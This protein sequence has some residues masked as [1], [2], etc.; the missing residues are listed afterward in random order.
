MGGFL[1]HTFARLSNRP[2]FNQVVTA[3]EV[4]QMRAPAEAHGK[5]RWCGTT[6]PCSEKNRPK[7]GVR[8]EIPSQAATTFEELCRPQLQKIFQTAYRITR[9]REDAE[10]AVQ[11][12][13]LQAFLH[14]RDFDGRS[15][16]STWLTRIAINSA[17]M[18]LRKRRTQRSISL[19]GAGDTESAPGTWEVPD[20]SA[21]PEQLYLLG[22]RQRKLREAV[23]T[24]RPTIR[25]VIE[26]QQLEER[27]MKD[28]AKMMGI[29]VCAAKGRLFHGKVALRRSRKLKLLCINGGHTVAAVPADKTNE[30][31]QIHYTGN[32]SPSEALSA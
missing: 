17:L 14:L 1:V 13:L 7:T 27:S 32:A 19:D 12:T 28:A 20:P 23:A 22:E 11:D 15:A 18:T 4:R 6:S 9:N 25:Q 21:H 24:L 30:N 10:D 2:E 5:G 3:K 31:R 26:V 8:T 16:F 29:S